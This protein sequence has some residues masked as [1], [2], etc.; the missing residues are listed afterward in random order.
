MEP[1]ILA[2]K[3]RCNVLLTRA[4]FHMGDLDNAKICA[5]KA[6]KI[7]KSMIENYLKVRVTPNSLKNLLDLT[8]IEA[9]VLWEAMKLNAV[10]DPLWI[11][12]LVLWSEKLIRLNM[13]IL[14][15][16]AY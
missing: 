16:N 2:I 13:S 7:V 4:Y 10:L 8:E 3:L 9:T 14:Q 5:L 1:I 12:D 11:A 6:A 15:F